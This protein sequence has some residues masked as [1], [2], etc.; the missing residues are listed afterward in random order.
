MLCS[1]CA[2]SINLSI[3][4]SSI[5]CRRN[6]WTILAFSMQMKN[7]K[8]KSKLSLGAV[9]HVHILKKSPKIKKH[10]FGLSD[11]FSGIEKN[12]KHV[13]ANTS[14]SNT[15]W[16]SAF[17][18]NGVLWFH[19]C[20]YVSR[21]VGE[22]IFSKM[23]HKIFLKLLIKLR[24]LKVKKMMFKWLQRDSNPQPLSS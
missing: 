18:C 22:H 10:V 12:L 15:F 20:Q 6:Q 13:E 19:H 14:V 23:A 9:K 24:C 4:K 3:L 21:S 17:S 8:N 5:Y 11:G 16:T 2:W 7:K 1:W